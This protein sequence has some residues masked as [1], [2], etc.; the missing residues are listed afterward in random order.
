LTNGGQW[1]VVGLWRR[2]GA[3][4]AGLVLVVAVSVACSD[5]PPRQPASPSGA[6][7]RAQHE[8]HEHGGSSSTS[9]PP[10]DAEQPAA[11]VL[12]GDESFPDGFTVPEGEV[13]EL[14][15][16]A[17]TTVESGANVVVEGVLRMRPDNADVRHTLRFVGVDESRFVGGGHDVVDS[18]VG[19]WV[20]GVGQLDIAGTP[21]AGW[22]RT[23]TDPAWR[24]G[25]DVRVAPSA[26]GDHERFGPF[27]P[28][29]PVPTASYAGQ[30]YAT[31][32]LNLTRNVRIE[33]T[34]DGGAD[35]AVNGRAHIWIDSARPQSIRY[36]E[37]VHLG[38]RQVSDGDDPTE[39]VTGRYPLHFH[40]AGDGSRGSIVE[41]VVV[42]DSGN[43]A[44]VPHAS[45][46]ITFR[47][48]I[49]FDVFEDA[50]WWDPDPGDVPPEN[51]TD[52]LVYDHA[53]A[54]LIR[55][56]PDTGGYALNGFTLGEGRNL[57][58]TDSVAVGVLGGV[59]SSGFHWPESANTND[60]SP[61]VWEFHGNV[62]HNNRDSGIFVWQNDENPH[63]VED[64]VGYRNGRYGVD[65]GAYFNDYHYD[66]IVAFENGE[67]GIRSEAGSAGTQRWTAIDTD[68]ILISDRSE[69]GDIPVVFDGLTLRG[70][71][72]VDEEDAP[73][74]YEFRNARRADGVELVP[75][76]FD[77][78][79]QASTIT[80][81]RADGTTTE[82]AA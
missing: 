35:P 10:P 4:T 2:T 38:P 36:A 50:Y 42:R 54:A 59:T 68:S 44:F 6:E 28:G 60:G 1:A 77:V 52:D 16:A 72:V 9:S 55:S 74:A 15:P 25:D 63:L 26:P 14:D 49:A 48:T 57:T 69:P 13:W 37:L 22:N 79:N 8:A 47:D 5:A 12:R 51:A 43:R 7:T 78:R 75:D 65:H 64:F 45:H 32:V 27:E 29:S 34:G 76:D 82:V 80:V 17:T 3:V 19:L 39:G 71:I 20:V 70:S 24:A 40:H 46:G 21:K 53:M 31:E 23:G 62:A 58:I 33:G 73:S 11:R 41:G 66:R 56:D 30:R 61:N 67:A 81:T 18:D